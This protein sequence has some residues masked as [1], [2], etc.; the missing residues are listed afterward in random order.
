MTLDDSQAELTP[1]SPFDYD[2]TTRWH[3]EP[4]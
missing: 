2:Y 1:A 3:L 4:G